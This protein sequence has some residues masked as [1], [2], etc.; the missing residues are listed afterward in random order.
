MRNRLLA[1]A[2]ACLTLVGA[3]VAAA[4]PASATVTEVGGGAV[5]VYE[6]FTTTQNSNFTTQTYAYPEVRLLAGGSPGLT[7][8]AVHVTE[9][10][11]MVTVDAVSVSTKGNLGGTPFAES[12]A[13]LVGVH[14]AGLDI[15]AIET[16]CLWNNSGASAQTSI[17]DLAGTRLN[18]PANTKIP[19][20]GGYAMINE[21]VTETFDGRTVITVAGVD[22]YFSND[23]GQANTTTR[24]LRLGYASCDPLKL[25]SITGLLSGGG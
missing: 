15:S 6:Q 24:S 17:V 20:P 13:K 23:H 22:L 11:H 16:H 10:A 12:S 3:V 21:Q 2:G 25:P 8:S 14:V 4:T 1:T 9:L 18:L 19:L 5:G 7:Q